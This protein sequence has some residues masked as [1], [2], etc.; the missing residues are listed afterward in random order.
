MILVF[1]IYLFVWEEVRKQIVLMFLIENNHFS[2]GCFILSGS[3][4]IV[5]IILIF[6]Y[7][8]NYLQFIGSGFFVGFFVFYLNFLPD[9]NVIIYFTYLK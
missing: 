8:F 9:P 2:G 4:I 5:I 7:I 6:T 3:F 1:S